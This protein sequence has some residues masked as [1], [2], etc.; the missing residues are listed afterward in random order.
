MF[1]EVL[2]LV[3]DYIYD[4]IFI[5]SGHFKSHIPTWIIHSAHLPCIYDHYGNFLRQISAY[6]KRHAS[7][8][9]IKHTALS[10]HRSY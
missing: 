8:W 1:S 9:S 3:V 4:T 2:F 6:E 5:Q 7:L 10:E